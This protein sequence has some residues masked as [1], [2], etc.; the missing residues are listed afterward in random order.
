MEHKNVNM[1]P[2]SAPLE[3]VETLQMKDGRIVDINIPTGITGKELGLKNIPQPEWLIPERI[4][5]GTVALAASP[6]SGK[7]M[8]ASQLAYAV[9][10]GGTFL[11]E[12]VTK[13]TVIYCDL[14]SSQRRSKERFQ[15]MGLDISGLDN[16]IIVNSGIKKITD[17][18][19]DQ[20]MAYKHRY[21][22]LR[23][24][25][26]DTLSK[27]SP[28]SSKDYQEETKIYSSLRNIATQLK[29]TVLLVHHKS[30]YKNDADPFASA[31]G[32][33]ALAGNCDV[34]ISLSVKNK[35]D[36]E[37]EMFMEG[38]DIETYRVMLRFEKLNWTVLGSPE[39]LEEQ[40]SAATVIQHPI[41][42]TIEAGIEKSATQ[43]S[44]QFLAKDLP[45]AAQCWGIKGYLGDQNKISR[46]IKKNT[47]II[48]SLLAVNVVSDR[49][50]SGTR[51]TVTKIFS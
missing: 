44:Y 14:E 15:K 30:K 40:L 11:D 27:V 2:A 18:L 20:L 12:P 42:K 5:V 23:L 6:K 31:Y 33:N 47:D 32:T 16:L 1:S 26:I 10:T 4:P 49:V 34:L 38:N 9:A 17:G 25:V 35:G 46:W 43:G 19:E 37:V 48:A 21:R 41:F 7:T 13:G 22:D 36:K 50:S 28:G 45:F 29:T 51:F 8:W 39:E 3:D 24:V